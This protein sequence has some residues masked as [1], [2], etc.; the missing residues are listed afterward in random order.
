M[1]WAFL[2]NDE[3]RED[4]TDE[5]I[6]EKPGADYYEGNKV[7]VRGELAKIFSWSLWLKK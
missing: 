4:N 6:Q 2:I 5:K 7:E 3:I 1:S